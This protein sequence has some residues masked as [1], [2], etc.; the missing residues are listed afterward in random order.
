MLITIIIWDI[1]KKKNRIV[2]LNVAVGPAVKEQNV[3]VN[4]L[5][6][7]CYRHFGGILGG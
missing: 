7:C 1:W 2:N 3:T 5:F 6:S 4:L